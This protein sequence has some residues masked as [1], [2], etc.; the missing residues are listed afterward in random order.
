MSTETW[1]SWVFLLGLIG[2]YMTPAMV[3]CLRGHRNA[4]AVTAFN[5]L[6]GWTF[7]GWILALVWSLTND[8]R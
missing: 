8:R 7:F 6:L 1:L 2:C 3:A 5:V 4:V